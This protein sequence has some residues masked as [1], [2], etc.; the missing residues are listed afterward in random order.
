M[1]YHKAHWP[2][3]VGTAS[4][5][6]ACMHS[7]NC[8]ENPF[9][10]PISFLGNLVEG[11]QSSCEIKSLTI[12]SW[13]AFDTPLMLPFQ[14]NTAF[15]LLYKAEKIR[16]NGGLVPW[17]LDGLLLQPE[18]SYLSERLSLR[19]NTMCHRIQVALHSQI[20]PNTIGSWQRWEPVVWIAPRTAEVWK[21]EVG[22]HGVLKVSKGINPWCPTFHLC[23]FLVLMRICGVTL[24]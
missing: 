7:R 6:L 16:L 19:K 23:P 8:L 17:S 18:L 20:H 22:L 3:A 11:V 13:M 9:K 14:F 12:P 21:L 5:W 24:R 4:R 2:C 10:T 15:P 1:W